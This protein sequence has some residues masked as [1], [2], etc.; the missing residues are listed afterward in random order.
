MIQENQENYIDIDNFFTMNLGNWLTQKTS[1]NPNLRKHTTSTTTT[2][3]IKDTKQTIF[4]NLFDLPENNSYVKEEES[5]I[6]NVTSQN[7]QD[8]TSSIVAYLRNNLSKSDGVLYKLD[9]NNNNKMIKGKFN[10]I[11]GVLKIIIIHNDLIIEETIWFINQNLKLSKSIIKQNDH[12]ILI[13]FTSEIKI[14]QKD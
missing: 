9:K 3:I 4:A 14:K 10:L 13:E 2:C 5:Q 7:D 12:C 8:N 1:Y 6:Y 11:D